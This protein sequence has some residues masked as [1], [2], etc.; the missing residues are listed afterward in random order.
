MSTKTL[1]ATVS[2]ALF[3]FATAQVALAQKDGEAQFVIIDANNRPTLKFT[4]KSAKRQRCGA[5]VSYTQAGD[6]EEAIVVRVAHLHIGKLLKTS[7]PE[8][9]WLY[10]TPTRIVF[11]VEAGDQSHAFDLR[12]AEL[13]DDKPVTNLGNVIFSPDEVGMQIHLKE[14]PAALG[15]STQ[16]FVFY[17]V[18]DRCHQINPGPYT[19][20]LKRAVR[21]FDG[22]VTEFKQ[23]ADSLKQS[24]RMLQ[25]R[26]PLVPP[27]GLAPK[28][29]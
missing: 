19:D 28:A 18:G 1:T 12:R 4:N 11:S 10:I 24:G 22:A 26:T 23:L 27:G 29:P 21:D 9:G 16:K 8:S 20:F 15:T 13:R 3:F 17:I 2:L 14:K 6:E 7:A 5:L 25:A